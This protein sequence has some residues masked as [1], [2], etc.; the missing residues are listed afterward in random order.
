MSRLLAA[1]TAA[2]AT[3]A[4]VIGARR[5]RRWLADAIDD[6]FAFPLDAPAGPARGAH[7]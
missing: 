2:T 7:R 5:L 3:A 4:A 6:A 1:A